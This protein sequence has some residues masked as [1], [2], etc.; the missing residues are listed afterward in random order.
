M[1]GDSPSWSTSICTR[2]KW[3]QHATS[4]QSAK[5]F[6]AQSPA[7]QQH[8]GTAGPGLATFHLDFSAAQHIAQPAGCLQAI[9]AGH[10]SVS[11]TCSRP[12]PP[13]KVRDMASRRASLM[14]WSWAPEGLSGS[15]ARPDKAG[16][17]TG[18]APC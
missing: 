8:D 1:G 5:Q 3:P 12:L 16:N 18:R 9:Q 14:A 6:A 15:P 7:S 17:D 11:P 10:F 2:S 4:Q 13:E